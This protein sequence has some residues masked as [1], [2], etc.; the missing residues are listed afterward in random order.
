MTD[1][2]YYLV[3][4]LT[5]IEQNNDEDLEEKISVRCNFEF[6]TINSSIPI[7]KAKKDILGKSDGKN[8]SVL[9]ITT[10]YSKFHKLT[11]FD[12]DKSDD[13]WFFFILYPRKSRRGI[14]A[15]VAYFE[16]G[17]Y[18]PTIPLTVAYVTRVPAEAETEAPSYYR[19]KLLNKFPLLSEDDWKSLQERENEL[20]PWV[21]E[22]RSLCEFLIKEEE[23]VNAIESILSNI[24]PIHHAIVHDVGQ[25]SFISLF[26]SENVVLHL[27]AG[28]PISWNMK[29]APK[30]K[31]N[32]SKSRAPVI[33]SHWDWDHISGYYH[34]E[35]LKEC[36]WIVPAQKL[37]PG[38]TK[39]ARDLVERNLLYKISKDQAISCNGIILIKTSN[40]ITNINDLRYRERYR[41]ITPRNGYV[42]NNSG[43][44]TEIPF[45]SKKRLLYVGDAD[46]RI[47]YLHHNLPHLYDKLKFSFTKTPDFLVVTHH[48]ADSQTNY[49]EYYINEIPRANENPSQCVVSV[50]KGNVYRHPSKEV[51]RLHREEGWEIS[52]TCADGKKNRG[53]KQLGP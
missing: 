36:P 2:T 29:T 8:L 13:D 23:D 7:E 14:S 37:G 52:L 5:C 27:D 32:T 35:G 45:S 19:L 17:V 16:A 40:N 21:N 22:V 51:L 30:N 10:T 53:D 44:L 41:K 3:G 50:G 33:I 34:L 28:W 25:A 47:A 18:G 1:P 26:S 24:P 46:Y 11:G 4:R 48:G 49:H 20:V 31:P 15:W 39:I 42:N 9:R 38:A 12:I 6:D 43:I